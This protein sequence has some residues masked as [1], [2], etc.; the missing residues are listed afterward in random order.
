M[1]NKKITKSGLQAICKEIKDRH[2]RQGEETTLEET[3]TLNSIFSKYHTD[4]FLKT[5]G[6]AVIKY[7]LKLDEEYHKN[8]CFW[9]VTESGYSTDIGYSGKALQLDYNYTKTNAYKL[10]NVKA[11]CRSAIDSVIEP[12]R[13]QTKERLL[14]G[15]VIYSG[16]DGVTPLSVGSFHVDHFD[17]TFDEIAFD[18]IL[19]KGLD[20]LYDK[21]N[22][23]AQQST[24]TE[25]VDPIL[26][27]E[28]L[29]YHESGITKLRIVTQE[30]NLS[31]LRKQH[32]QIV[33]EQLSKIDKP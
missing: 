16:L 29:H 28:F 9:L 30:Q 8:F 6:E 5:N 25:F 4:W 12:I 2:L 18:W 19:K 32:N 7:V 20:Y 21:V 24:K 23:G 26:N 17:R 3:I 10:A 13:K 14:K 27:D 1:V 11:A 31:E 15:E 33:K 22:M